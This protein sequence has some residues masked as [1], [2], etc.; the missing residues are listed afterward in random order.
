MKKAIQKYNDYIEKNSDNP[1]AY[2]NLGTIYQ[3]N[4]QYN[5]AINYFEKSNKFGTKQF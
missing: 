5:D 3:K 2:Y 4:K 1:V